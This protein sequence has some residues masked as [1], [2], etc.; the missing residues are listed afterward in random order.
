MT[1]D[2]WMLVSTAL[3]C[4]LIPNV[5]ITGLALIPGGLP[6]GFGNRDTPFAVPAWIERARRAH[7]NMVE[8]LAPFA[9][10][11]LVAH[12]AGKAD[13]TTALGAQIFFVSRVAH[14]AIYIIGIPYLRT[15]AFVGGV[16]GEVMILLRILA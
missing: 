14:A 6:W 3:L 10:L 16:I 12:V 11:V 9:C 8:N 4:M 1:T 2:L 15:L 7:M 5:G 13:A